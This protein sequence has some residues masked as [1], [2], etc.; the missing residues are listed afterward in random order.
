M[1]HPIDL[2]K[3]I[4]DSEGDDVIV[5]QNVAPGTHYP[6]VLYWPAKLNLHPTICDDNLN[7]KLGFY[8][9]FHNKPEPDDIVYAP[10]AAGSYY[11]PTL[12]EARERWPEGPSIGGYLELNRTK[13]TATW[14]D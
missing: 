13:K 6:H 8:V 1:S 5:V 12:Q 4:I 7:S 9:T 11:A 14:V 3:P 2:N 10:V